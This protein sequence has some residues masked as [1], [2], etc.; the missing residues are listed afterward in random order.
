MSRTPVSLLALPALFAVMPCEA[1]GRDGSDAAAARDAPA[2]VP[3]RSASTETDDEIV[4]TAERYG[5]AKVA[6]ESEFSEEE[7]AGQGTDSIQDL[8]TRLAPFIDGSGEAPIILINGKPAGFDRSILFYPAE[9]LDRLAVLKPEAAAQYGYAPGKRVVNL[10]LKKSYSSLNVDAGVNWATAGG[11]YGGNLSAGRVAISGPVRWNVNARLGRDSALRKDAR[12]IPRPAT[13]FDRVGY[14]AGIDGGEI[15]PALSAAAGRLV[16]VAAIPMGAAPS[17]PALAD[18]AGTADET[19]AADPHAFDTLQSARRSSTL[20]LGVTRPVGGF[21]ASLSLNAS[22][23]SS[24]GLRGL[25]MA[26]VVVPAGSPWSP[27]AGDVLLIRPFA[28]DRPLRNDNSSESLGGS[29]T[30]NGVIGGWQTSLGLNYVRSW[31]ENLFETGIDIARVQGLIDAGDVA[32][33]PYGAWDDSLL[34]GNRTRT[35]SENLSGRLQLQKAVTDLP[36]GPLNASFAVNASRGSSESRQ[37]GMRGEP[38]VIDTARAQLDGRLALTV[39]V[40]RRG[41]SEI[42]PLGDMTVDVSIGGQAMSSS[43]LQTQFGGGINWSPVSRV[44]LRGSIDHAKTAPSFD[45]LDAPIETRVIRIF[46]YARGE[47]AEPVSLTGGNPDLGRGSRQSL[48]LNATVR[49]FDDQTLSLTVEYRQTIAKGG[50]ASFPELTPVIEAAFPE[51]VTRDAAG[52][53]VA[54]DARAINIARE[55]D[56]GLNSGIAL[57]LPALGAAARAAPGPDPLQFSVSLNHRWRLKSELLTRPGVPV[58]DQLADS[59][60]SRHNLSL[61]ITA[62]KRGIGASFNGNWASAATVS[63]ADRRFRFK[64]PLT[65]NLSM[66]VEPGRLTGQSGE[67]GLTKDLKLSFDIQNLFNGYRR[68]TLDDGSTPPGY[69]RDEIDPLGRTVR[70]TFRK[71]F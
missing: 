30:L 15:D 29:L 12:N 14:V 7:I 52:R 44:Q 17:A 53:L 20:S 36:A 61:Q 68:I 1:S 41:K 58:I 67:G 50:I 42:G 45:Q 38:F 23:N 49:P 26:S 3:P 69:T 37:S 60:Q 28:G 16:V 35:K 24:R 64:P 63:N 54:V 25:P 48:A 22:R 34:L 32:F 33:N 47:V 59:G 55:T 70:V 46:D 71:R 11:Q 39:P 10:V 19:H 5:E 2:P 6:A 21:T 13:P 8:L 31:G 56:T 51:R 66:F 4:V 43:P 40:S 57:R 18:F 27:F 65:F 9:A 62:G